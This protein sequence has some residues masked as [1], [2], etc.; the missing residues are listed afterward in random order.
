MAFVDMYKSLAGGEIPGVSERLAK[1]KINEALGNFYDETDWS[2]QTQYGGWLNPGLVASTGTVTVTPGVNTVLGDAAASA[3]WAAIKFPL[4]TQL[5]F[6][7]PSYSLYNVVG[8]DGVSTLTLDRP[9]M[10]PVSGAGNTYWMYQAYFAVPVQDFRKFTYI[11]DTTDNAP[12]DFS[13]KSQADLAQDDPQRLVFGPTVPTYAVPYGVDQRPGSSTLG[14]QLW[15]IWPHNLSY[16]PYT[17]GY[18]RRGPRLI[19]PADT[20]PYPMTD[21]L[22]TWRAKEILYLFKEAQKGEGAQR[23]NGADWRFLAE[24]ARVQWDGKAGKGGLLRNIRAIDANL[25]HD[26]VTRPKS[27]SCGASRDGYSTMRTGQLNIGTM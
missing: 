1:N 27:D 7:N 26:F 23:G 16:M 9:W 10:E 24:Y 5:Q 2:F 21:D 17:L 19:N 18:K 3:A 14:W 22:V 4:I 20:V 12:V 6:R 25:H 13:R 11:L 8:Y 15:E